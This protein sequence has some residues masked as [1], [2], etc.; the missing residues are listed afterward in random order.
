M[1]SGAFV[2]LVFGGLGIVLV[3]LLL[4]GRFY[5][6]SGADVLDWE[7][8]R[9]AQLEAELEQGD[10]DQMLAAQNE[11]RRM[12]GAPE[13]TLEDLERDVAADLREY[14]EVQERLREP[15]SEGAGWP[16]S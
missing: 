3:A 15:T 2:F 9:S 16:E 1:G 4:I 11:W 5:P 8:T 6:G 10:I 12:R 13:R 7:P 14:R